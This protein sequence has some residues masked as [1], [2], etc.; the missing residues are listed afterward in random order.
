M[1]NLSLFCY[2]CIILLRFTFVMIILRNLQLFQARF[3]KDLKS[4]V[5]GLH[6][7]LTR[8]EGFRKPLSFGCLTTCAGTCKYLEVIW[9]VKECI[10]KRFPV[11]FVYLC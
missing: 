10:F 3:A 2:I 9:F 4:R 5:F 1:A 6:E 11:L 8:F 7:N